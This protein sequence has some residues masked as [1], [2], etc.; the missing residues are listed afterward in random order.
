MSH[1]RRGA[2]QTSTP[3]TTDEVL[4]SLANYHE[5]RSENF[6]HLA[7][8]AVDERVHILLDRLVILEDVAIQVIREERLRLQPDR[9]TYLPLGPTTTIEQ[10]SGAV[11]R[12]SSHPTIDDAVWCAL[13]SD[14]ALDELID[15]LEA[16]SA[17]SSVREL[18]SRL[19]E[20]ERTRDRQIA[21]FVR[22]D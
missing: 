21:N 22:E 3:H 12:C 10:G 1:V 6:Q 18:A 11:C 5:L 7:E 20:L 16:S 9:G 15:L 13:S 17:A 8:K 4:L 2:D 14:E 19:R